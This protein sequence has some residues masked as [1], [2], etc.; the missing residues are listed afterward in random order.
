[1]ACPYKLYRPAEKIFGLIK[2][3]NFAENG[4]LD[5]ENGCIYNSVKRRYCDREVI[6]SVIN[7]KI[8]K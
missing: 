4:E 1:M 5:R 8:K 2:Q 3:G 7:T 6:D